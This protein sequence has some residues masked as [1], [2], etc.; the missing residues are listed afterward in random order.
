MLLCLWTASVTVLKVGQMNGC[1]PGFLGLS[2][3]SF[4]NFR[5]SRSGN[6]PSPASLRSLSQSVKT[7]IHSLNFSSL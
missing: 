2:V 7:V 4:F 3:V 5:G 1:L 6:E